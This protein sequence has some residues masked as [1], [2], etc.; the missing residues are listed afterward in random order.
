MKKNPRYRSYFFH[1][2]RNKAK[3][4]IKGLYPSDP[5]D[6]FE[7]CFSQAFLTILSKIEDGSY[8][9]QNLSAFALKVV[10]LTYKNQRRKS[11]SYVTFTADIPDEA[12]RLVTAAT[13]AEDFFE[14]Y[15]LEQLKF[16][17]RRLPKLKRQIF[18]L[19]I[20]GFDHKEIA[21][22]L[23]IAY[24]TLRNKY[25]ELIAEARTIKESS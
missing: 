12:P 15:Q 19:K 17:Y 25:S 1:S 22:E 21:V 6:W 4:M 2:I 9:D 23:G 18:D 14:I 5:S 13:S 10:R 11:R 3:M 7:D 24:G 20:Q 8:E 16:W